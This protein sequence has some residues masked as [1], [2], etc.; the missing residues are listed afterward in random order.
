LSKIKRRL[1]REPEYT[2][3]QPLYALYVFGP[4]ART[5][6]WAVLDKSKV[7]APHYDV[8]FFDRNA[9]GDL[10]AAD[11]R[12]EGTGDA[13]EVTFDIGS[14]TDRESQQTHTGLSIRH[15]EGEYAITMFRMK[16]CDKVP[17]RGGYAP[18]VGPYTQFA[19]TP[20]RPRSSGR[21]PMAHSASSSGNLVRSILA[22]RKTCGSFWGI[23]G[24]AGTLSVPSPTRFCQKTSP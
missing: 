22:G 6:V 1:A 16:W 4:Q 15:T 2:S 9:D 3:K 18:E 21:E 20:A 11:E 8:L 17:I 5:H 10:T 14:F 23:R 13:D 12:I 19:A 24:S 7:D